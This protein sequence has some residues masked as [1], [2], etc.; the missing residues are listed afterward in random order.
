MHGIDLSLMWATM[1]RTASGRPVRA[2]Q[3]CLAVPGA[4]RTVMLMLSGPGGG[5]EAA[6]CGERVACIEAACA[7]FAG[8]EGGAKRDVKLAQALPEP[9]EPWSVRAFESAGF[10][11]VGDLAYLRRPLWPPLVAPEPPWPEGISVRNVRGVAPG[12]PDRALLLAALNRSYEETLDCPELC[13][14]RETEDILESHRATGSFDAKLWWLVMLGNEP[15]GCML[16]SRCPD[17][18]SVEL[19]YL[20]LSPALRGRRMGSRLLEF[21]IASLG[22]VTADSLTC[23]VDLRN[24]PARRLYARTGFREFGRRVAMVRAL[25][26][27]RDRATA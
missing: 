9:G 3:V 12:E 8:P 11:K 10:V 2:R 1:D 14:L 5:D 27:D 22:A 17:H 21:G 23:A 26:P 15:Q 19:V 25:R 7:F 16:L 6:E 4:G 20:G 18:N 24:E 13:G